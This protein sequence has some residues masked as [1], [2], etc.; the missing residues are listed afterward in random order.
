MLDTDRFEKMVKRFGPPQYKMATMLGVNEHTI[1]RWKWT[2]YPLMGRLATV[3]E[4]HPLNILDVDENGDLFISYSRVDAER[5]IK[6]MTWDDLATVCGIT[7]AGLWKACRFR[8][9]PISS[10]ARLLD[11]SP[12]Y[13][14]M[15]VDEEPR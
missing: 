14:L 13:L 1:G 7:R 6:G 3:L 2:E 11:V 15:F 4:C 9:R 5:H 10:L 8:H 12:L